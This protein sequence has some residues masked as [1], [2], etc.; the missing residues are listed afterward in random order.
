M[1]SLDTHSYDSKWIDELK[2]VNSKHEEFF[3]EIEKFPTDIDIIN[4]SR[5]QQ[6]IKNTALAWRQRII[7]GTE[8]D[9]ANKVS[10]KDI[11]LPTEFCI[12]YRI[13]LEKIIDA[14]DAENIRDICK[15]YSI[16]TTGDTFNSDG[17]V[18][19]DNSN[20]ESIIAA[21][22]V[23]IIDNYV[24]QLADINNGSCI[25]GQTTRLFQIYRTFYS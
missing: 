16:P 14:A 19:V 5:N 11:L 22:N 21:N 25:Q 2:N 4:I 12:L 24:E 17:P 15:L 1:T 6:E 3:R 10:P 20:L 18:V 13:R 7:S 23:S 9:P 8:V